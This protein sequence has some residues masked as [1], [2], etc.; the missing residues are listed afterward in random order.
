MLLALH[1]VSLARR[2]EILTQLE[3]LVI[4]VLSIPGM[5]DIVEVKAQLSEMSEVG[6][7]DLL[8]RDPVAP[9][10]DLMTTNII[11]KVVLITGAGGYWLRI[12][13]PNY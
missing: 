3:P 11:N 12:M 9:K 7:D 13:P 6:V 8:G 10:A 4:K 5:A 2:K 1:R